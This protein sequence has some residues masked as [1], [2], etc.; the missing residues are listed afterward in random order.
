MAISEWFSPL[1]KAYFM[2]LRQRFQ[3]KYHA[4]SKEHR[5]ETRF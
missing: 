5:T 1:N 4:L 2:Y 3:R